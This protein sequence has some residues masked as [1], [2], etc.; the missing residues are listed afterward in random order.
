MHTIKF[1][2]LMSSSESVSLLPHPE[3][4][5]PSIHH[6]LPLL[7][8]NRFAT[9]PPHFHPLLLF[10]SL[11]SPFFVLPSHSSSFPTNL[12]SLLPHHCSLASPVT[13]PPPSISSIFPKPPSI[14]NEIVQT[15]KEGL[16]LLPLSLVLHSKQN[17]QGIVYNYNWG[18]T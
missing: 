12:T 1:S 13:L 9:L 10:S 8:L 14:L 7:P 18:K 11:P 4:L 16:P 17:Y 2:S 6:S 5:L 3:I 15:E